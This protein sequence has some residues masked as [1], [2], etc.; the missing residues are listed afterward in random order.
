MTVTQEEFTKRMQTCAQY[1]E[2]RVMPNVEG[3]DMF[4]GLGGVGPAVA[5][6]HERPGPSAVATFSPF[7]PGVVTADACGAIG[8]VAASVSR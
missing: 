1:H 7:S 5:G 2:A 4:C 3:Q 8:A 6:Q